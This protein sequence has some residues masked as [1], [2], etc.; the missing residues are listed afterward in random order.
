MA[1]NGSVEILSLDINSNAIYLANI[2]LVKVLNLAPTK[3]KRLLTDLMEIV[4]M[5]VVAASTQ[6]SG[7]LA[8]LTLAQLK[9]QDSSNSR[10]E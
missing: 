3:K 4:M 10:T 5:I 9:A 1:T 7:Q 6:L 2:M 8:K